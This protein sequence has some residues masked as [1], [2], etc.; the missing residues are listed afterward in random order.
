M[1]GAV[2]FPSERM[3]HCHSRRR[4]KKRWRRKGKMGESSSL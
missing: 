4:G 2:L 1:K 3:I